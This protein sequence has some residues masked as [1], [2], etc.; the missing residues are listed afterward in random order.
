MSLRNTIVNA[1]TAQ[2]KRYPKSLQNV[3][4]VESIRDTCS[5]REERDVGYIHALAT[6]TVTYIRFIST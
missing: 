2:L 5:T 4:A 6:A 3:I 1:E